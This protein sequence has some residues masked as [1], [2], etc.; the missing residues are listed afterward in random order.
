MVVDSSTWSRR[1]RSDIAS[2]LEVDERNEFAALF[3]QR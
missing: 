1:V 2:C 3:G